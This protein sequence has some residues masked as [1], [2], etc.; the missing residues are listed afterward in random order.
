VAGHPPD[1]LSHAGGVWQYRRVSGAEEATACCTASAGCTDPKSGCSGF[2]YSQLTSSPR[3]AGQD[4]SA[5]SQPLPEPGVS[6][7]L[8]RALLCGGRCCGCPSARPGSGAALPCTFPA[9]KPSGN[10]QFCKT[11]LLA[12]P[13]ILAFPFLSGTLS[14]GGLRSAFSA[15]RIDSPRRQHRRPGCQPVCPVGTW[16]VKAGRCQSREGAWLGDPRLAAPL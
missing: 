3:P 2:F 10:F 13:R 6:G 8:G 15:Q 11:T 9:L 7:G 12:P 14:C 4:P 1:T 16:G 5:V